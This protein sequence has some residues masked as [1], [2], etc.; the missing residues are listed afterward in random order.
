MCLAVPAKVIKIDKDENSA[1]VDYGGVQKTTRLDLV[2]AK[3]GDYILIHAGFAI[4][5]V[6]EESALAS[7]DQI[8][9]IL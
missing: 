1:V 9:K 4:E 7:L 8:N 5:V 3:V 6:D 2:D